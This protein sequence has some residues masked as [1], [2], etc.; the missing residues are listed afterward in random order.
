MK[1]ENQEKIP[2][3]SL[4]F[5][6]LV[7]MLATSAYVALGKVADPRDK[8]VIR[9]LD[10]AQGLIDLIATLKSKTSGNL[11]KRESDYIES[12]LTDLRLNFV[13]EKE[14]P[15]S[16]GPDDGADSSRGG[17]TSGKKPGEDRPEPDKPR[18]I[19][20]GQE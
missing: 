9:N 3:D 13:R 4:R 1:Q 6:S 16:D 20:P 10:E 5:L 8:K 18:I 12:V 11:D 19:I 17:E 14:K 7:S 2:V 15:G